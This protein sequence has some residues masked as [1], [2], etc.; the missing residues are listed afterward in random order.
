MALKFIPIVCLMLFSTATFA[1]SYVKKADLPSTTLD[2]IS[3]VIEWKGNLYGHND[4]GGDPVIFEFDSTDGSAQIIKRI[5]LGGATNHDWEDITQDDDYIYVGDFG[6]NIDGSRKDLKFYKVPK[7][8][9]SEITGDAGTI[10]ASDIQI[11]NFS[12]P[13]QT[14]FC[15]VDFACAVDK[16]QFDCEAVIYDKGKL[17]L[18]TKDWVTNNT[19]QHYSVPATAGTYVA[20]KLDNFTTDGVLITS[21]TKMNDITIALLGYNN[22]DVVGYSHTNA[23]IWLISGFTDMDH[24]FSSATSTRKI[25]LGWVIQP[26]QA[27]GITAVKQRRA[28]ITSERIQGT[29]DLGGGVKLPVN[30]TPRLGG[31][32]FGN[33]V[34]LPE[35]LTN[36]TSQLSNNTVNLTWEYDQPGASYFEVEASASGNNDDFKSIGKV[37]SSNDFTVTYR[38][39][40]DNADFSG[41][42]YYRIRIVTLDSQVYYSKIL[43]V[44]KNDGNG[45]NLLAAPSPF[46]DKL[47][48]SFFSNTKQYVQLSVVDMYGRTLQTHRLQCL[49]GK[50]NY[51]MEGLSG[52]S[53]GVYFITGR[54]KDNLFIRKVLKQ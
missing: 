15:P 40:D 43:S 53:S 39:T 1:Q 27:E 25:D 18:F 33:L 41:E 3:G 23:W 24:V 7:Q 14:T 46:S 2:E 37:N 30:I 4:S 47:E 34:T 42:Q 19:T 38:F 51:S 54:T 31:V 21:A 5:T 9:I 11:I 50:Y 17:H 26:G 45:F 12:Y 8:S 52:L 6:N 48:I 28:L 49:P 16:T 29:I 36:F 44:R 22:K 32:N 13:D 20:T 10:P 35:G